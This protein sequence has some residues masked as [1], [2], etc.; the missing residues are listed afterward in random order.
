MRAEFLKRVNPDGTWT[1]LATMSKAEWDAL[2]GDPMSTWARGL[3]TRQIT[4]NSMPCVVKRHGK[5]VKR[6][7]YFSFGGDRGK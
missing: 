7:D 1:P 6:T 4:V 2:G 3:F 5:G